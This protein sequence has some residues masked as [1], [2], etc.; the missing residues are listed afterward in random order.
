M[1]LLYELAARTDC[2]NQRRLANLTVFIDPVRNPDGRDTNTRTTAF[3]FDANRDL[4]F[5]TQDVNAAVAG[6][7]R[8]STPASSSSTPTSRPR[9]SS[10]RRPTIPP[11]TSSPDFATD[12]LQDAIGPALQERF[13]DQGLQYRSYNTYDRFS[14]SSADTATSLFMGAAGV[15]IEKG[16]SEVYGKQVY[17]L[18]LAMDD[19][20]QRRLQAQGRARQ[21]WVVAVGRGRGAGRGVRAAGQPADEPG[22]PAAERRHHSAARPTGSAAT[23]SRRATQR[24][25]VARVIDLLRGRGVKVYT[26]RRARRGHR[27]ARLRRDRDKGADA[28]RRDA[29]TSRP[30]RR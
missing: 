26:A 28:G 17:D 4:A 6:R 30:G 13:N 15:L 5:Q 21:G 20:A 25:D 29:S 12:T 1:R 19:D 10:S 14:P 22:A 18:Y 23:T 11:C 8:R 16:S 27:V 7:D 9:A 2:A 3:A 24:G